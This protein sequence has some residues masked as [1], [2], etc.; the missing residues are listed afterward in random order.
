MFLEVTGYPLHNA[1][2][3]RYFVKM[4]YMQ[5]FLGMPVNFS[6][7]DVIHITHDIQEESTTFTREELKFIVERSALEIKSTKEE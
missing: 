6:S 2:Y 3:S 1:D 4:I 7:K 5:F